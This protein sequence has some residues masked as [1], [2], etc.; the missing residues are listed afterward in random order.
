MDALTTKKLN[1]EEIFALLK[2]FI[3]EVIGEE[4]V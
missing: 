3:T 1:G 2:S 4:F